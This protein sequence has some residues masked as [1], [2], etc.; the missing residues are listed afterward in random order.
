MPL[1]GL[2]WTQTN[3]PFTT[4]NKKIL[5]WIAMIMQPPFA[6]ETL[7]KDALE[8]VQKKKNLPAL[9]KLRYEPLQ[10]GLSAQIMHI[11]P[12]SAEKPTIEKLQNYI[13]ENHYTF[14][15]KHHEIYLGDP[16][17]TAPEK[18]KTIIR[19]PIKK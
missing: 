15:G 14:N 1:E 18:L 12:Y 6:T 7:F 5:Q 16:R 19:Q 2:W 13:K 10:E 11:G 9:P 8:Q 17:K 4:N 3:I